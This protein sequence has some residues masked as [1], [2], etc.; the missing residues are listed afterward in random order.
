[1]EIVGHCQCI[2]D[3]GLAIHDDVQDL[4]AC[5]ERP[6]CWE[7]THVTSGPDFHEKSQQA[8]QAQGLRSSATN[9][10]GVVL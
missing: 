10:V 8:V 9:F 3:I 5:L 1:M 2:S 4:A 6:H 7:G